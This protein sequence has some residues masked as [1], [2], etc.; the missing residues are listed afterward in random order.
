[1]GMVRRKVCEWVRE[2][3][4]EQGEVQETVPVLVLE[5]GTE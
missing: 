5:R 4:R 2:E 3:A 1:M